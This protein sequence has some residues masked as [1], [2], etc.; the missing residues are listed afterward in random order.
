MGQDHPGLFLLAFE[1][2][3]I[4]RWEMSADKD[5]FKCDLFRVLRPLVK[6]RR[7]TWPSNVP[8]EIFDRLFFVQMLSVAYVE[9]QVEI[10]GPLVSSWI[11]RRD[12]FSLG[13]LAGS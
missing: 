7:V 12:G 10:L 3:E 9:S 5:G 4:D 1:M 13:L 11:T 6:C 2:R 8:I